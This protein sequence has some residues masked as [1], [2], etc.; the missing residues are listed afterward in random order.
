M[1]VETPLA[2]TLPACDLMIEAARRNGVHLEVAEN[3]W[4]YP[5]ERL[6]QRILQSGLAGEPLRGYCVY[7]TGGYHAVNGARVY[8]GGTAR[9]VWG[10]TR[11]WPVPLLTDH[12]GRRITEE[13][14]S[15]GVIEFDNE[16]TALVE[17]SNTYSTALRRDGPRY[18]GFAASR[19]HAFSPSYASPG[20]LYLLPDGEARP[21][22]MREETRVV[23]GVE[24]PQRF[25]VETDPPVVY[26]NPFAAY[27]VTAGELAAADELSSIHRAVAEG[28]EPEYGA[29]AGR[30][31]QEIAIALQE[32][33]RTG[34]PIEL[35]LTEVTG[36]EAAIHDRLRAEFGHDILD[37]EAL[38]DHIFP[39]R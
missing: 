34:R 29:V 2:V 25:Y 35:P 11:Q 14:W 26:E 7:P 38:L 4:R 20:T 12:A 8:V 17:Y 1:I 39:V 24:V 23:D 33:G 32:A 3:V 10:S 19:G 13:S 30:H 18:I 27:G 5:Y 36:H 16:R 28:V 9:R 21:Y 22:P 15:L 37:T 6:K 31:D